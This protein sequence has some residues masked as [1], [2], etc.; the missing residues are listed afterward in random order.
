[1]GVIELFVYIVLVVVLGFLATWAIGKLAPNHPA[2]I[3][4]IIWF[5]VVL[6]VF[7]VL[8]TAFGLTGFDPAVPRLRR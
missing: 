6:L 1:M 2:I 5:V 3:D 8:A 4:N 7:V